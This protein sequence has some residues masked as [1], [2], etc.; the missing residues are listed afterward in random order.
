MSFTTAHITTVFTHESYAESN[1]FMYE[2]CIHITR[3]KA[4]VL[5]VDKNSKECRLI[6]KYACGIADLN[7][8]EI[9][10]VNETL[11]Q[12]PETELKFSRFSVVIDHPRHSLVP[13]VFFEK[14]KA[15]LFYNQTNEQA[16]NEE[17]HAQKLP[18]WQSVMLF[19]FHKYLTT[20]F[21]SR[22]RGPRFIHQS[23]A[24]LSGAAK[25]FKSEDGILVNYNGR[26]ATIVYLKNKTPYFVN[27]FVAETDNDA[28]YF[29][30]ATMEEFM[31]PPTHPVFLSGEFEGEDSLLA[32]F[33]KYLHQV[34]WV[35]T[36]VAIPSS[37][38]YFMLLSAALCE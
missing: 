26:F 12:I 29:L 23:A 35:S 28:L 33:R 13:E 10:E 27:S 31:I 8:A 7:K 22:L 9:L 19:P 6:K 17:L 11:N 36:G 32:L 14:E 5:V 30:L 16:D 2:A 24:L 37:H 21:N 1:A 18:S 34:E 4:T 25:A 15:G 3:H 38:H 20:L